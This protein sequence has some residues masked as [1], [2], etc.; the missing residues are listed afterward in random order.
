MSRENVE[1]VR[2]FFGAMERFFEEYW[3]DPRS[4]VA[5]VETGDLWPEYR[6]ALSCAHP[7]AEWQTTFLG[8]THQGS[9]EIAKAW[10]DFL[11]WAEDYRVRLHEATD[12]GGDQVFAIL[13]LTSK[14]KDGN[15]LDAR[16]FDVIT[17]REGLIVRVAEYTNRPEALEAVGP[18]E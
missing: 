6:N 11:K 12:L 14:T 17:V 18:S 4:L 7:D 5:A 1:I 16:F 2:R 15:A 8:A 10:D 13:T 3:K 9:L